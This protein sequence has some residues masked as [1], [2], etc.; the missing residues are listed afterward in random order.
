[1]L[2]LL[3]GWLSETIAIIREKKSNLDLKF[4]M[5]YFVGSILL[6]WHAYILNDVVFMILNGFAAVMA[7][8]NFFYILKGKGEKKS[9]G[10][11]KRK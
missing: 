2:L 8:V 6:V 11:K 10:K 5:L 7:L 4:V 9:G 3:F 1:M